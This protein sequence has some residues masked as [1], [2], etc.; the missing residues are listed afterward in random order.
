MGLS[1]NKV[2]QAKKIVSLLGKEGA[3][4]LLVLVR[5]NPEK[6]YL[7]SLVDILKP[8]LSRVTIFSRLKE[9]EDLGMITGLPEVASEKRLVLRYKITQRG[10]EI[11]NRLIAL[12]ATGTRSIKEEIM[13]V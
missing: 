3:F 13:A 4:D 2:D 7:N 12:T 6:A 8:T 11:L 1:L 9:L 10:S 5:Q